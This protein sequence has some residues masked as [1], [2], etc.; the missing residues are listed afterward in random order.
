MNLNTVVMAKITNFLKIAKKKMLS[1][2]LILLYEKV[3]FSLW[4]R[5]KLARYGI[6]AYDIALYKS[7][8][9]FPSRIGTLVAMALYSFHRLIMGKVEIGNF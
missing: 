1:V 4:N 3:D 8:V 5:K 7:Y 6:P 2:V 9:F